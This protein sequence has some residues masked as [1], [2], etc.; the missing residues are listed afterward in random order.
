MSDS[1]DEIR[2][3]SICSV[4]YAD[5]GFGGA[6]MQAW[7]AGAPSVREFFPERPLPAVLDEIRQHTYPHRELSAI[8]ETTA[9]QLDAPEESRRNIRALSEPNTFVVVTGQQAGFLGGPLY[10]LYKALSTIALA[11]R[12]ERETG[13]RFVPVFWVAGDDHD[14]QEID[15]AYLQSP[16]GEPALVKAP[17]FPAGS[18]YAASD[19][20]FAFDP[21]LRNDLLTLLPATE[22]D[23]LLGAYLKPSSEAAFAA[24]MLRWL[25][26]HGLVV[27]LSSSLRPLAAPLLRRNLSDYATV[28]SEIIA[29]GK[30]MLAHAFQPGFQEN[31]CAPHFFMHAANGKRE[32]AAP[33]SIT[34]DEI[35]LRPNAFSAGAALRPI[36]QQTIFPVAAAVLGPGEISYWAQLRAAHRNYGAVW[37]MIVPRMSVTIVDAAAEKAVRKLAI[38]NDPRALFRTSEH[39]S[40][41]VVE[42]NAIAHMIEKRAAS[43]RQEFAAL[44]AE[45]PPETT[46]SIG[47]L[48]EKTQS[49]FEHRF[50]RLAR[51]AALKGDARS[52]SVLRWVQLLNQLIRPTGKPQERVYCCAQFLS[53]YPHLPDLLLERIDPLA[54]VHHIVTLP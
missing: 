7:A 1:S 36:V 33:N 26:R 45:L 8:L 17:T 11:R 23:A 53:R 3:G 31:R 30:A 38:A 13:A 20:Q 34:P 6:L 48:L 35:A 37:P 21:P 51:S 27:A 28:E 39:W 15:H 4:S 43:V 12:F 47:P 49:S 19:I 25:G 46:A 40:E 10:T 24:L 50:K 2:P 16:N 52:R 42:N 9:R 22:V 29:A 5:A 14:L 41:I 44:R 54:T 18:G 32:R